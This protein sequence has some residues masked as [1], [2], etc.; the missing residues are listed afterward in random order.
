MR[1]KEK[2]VICLILKLK[3][4]NKVFTKRAKRK[5]E[6]EKTSII[7]KSIKRMMKKLIRLVMKL[8]MMV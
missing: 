1:Y 8:K 2:E 6:E 5:R 4:K 3:K 7:N